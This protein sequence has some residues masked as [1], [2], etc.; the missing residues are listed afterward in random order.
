MLRSCFSVFDHLKPSY[1][2]SLAEIATNSYICL[3]EFVSKAKV[4]VFENSAE[5]ACN[6]E[7]KLKQWLQLNV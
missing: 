4:K 5:I 3:F 1:Y 7:L 6:I 2:L